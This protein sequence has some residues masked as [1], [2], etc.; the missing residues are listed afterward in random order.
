MC[1]EKP[2]HSVEMLL[3]IGELSRLTG[4]SQATLRAWERRH[5][6]LH[7]RRLPG[8]HRRYRAQ[9][10]E[11]IRHVLAERAAGA[12]MRLAIT[13]ARERV[14][15]PQTSI[16]ATLR[17]R[18]PDLQPQPLGVPMMLALSRAIED[19][20]LS[21]AERPV[22][23]GAFQRERFYRSS[24]SRWRE[25]A[26]GAAFAAVFADFAHPSEPEDGPA[27]VPVDRDHP[28]SR[29]WAVVCDATGHAV[30]LFGWERPGSEDAGR[31][32]DAVWSVEPD[33]VREAAR[34]CMQV[35]SAQIAIPEEVA[36]R[37]RSPAPGIAEEQLRL[38]TA[39]TARALAYLSLD[40]RAPA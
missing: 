13:R 7:P 10:A 16:Y 5:D 17:R 2:E 27:E 24:A 37:L 6:L 31:R 28:L 8:G 29:E 35:A 3:G 21:R 19:E 32:F 34:I 22:L 12:P 14:R 40:P 18:R 33:V 38:A 15:E 23:F 39:I 36:A 9:D 4:A 26:A 20:S 30:C 1:P 25:L 11:L